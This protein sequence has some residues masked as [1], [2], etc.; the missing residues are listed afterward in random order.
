MPDERRTRGKPERGKI[1]L[2]AWY[3]ENQVLIQVK[4]DGAGIDPDRVRESAVNKGLI[5]RELLP[6]YLTGK[7]LN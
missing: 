3:Q 5:T 1:T 2:S 6:G 7:R 4:D